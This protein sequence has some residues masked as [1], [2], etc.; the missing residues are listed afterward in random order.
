[1]V[2]DYLEGRSHQRYAS[3]TVTHNG[4][5]MPRGPIVHVPQDREPFAIGFCPDCGTNARETC[6]NRGMFD[7]PGC[8]LFWYDARVGEQTR[9]IEDYFSP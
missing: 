6:S 2:S 9:S 1:M 4:Y 7:C 8:P 3:R 5:G